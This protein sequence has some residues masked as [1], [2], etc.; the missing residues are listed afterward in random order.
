M[1]TV[2]HPK[3][4][5]QRDWKDQALIADGFLSYCPVKRITMVRMLPP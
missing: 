2:A 5:I 4:Y 1:T 3:V